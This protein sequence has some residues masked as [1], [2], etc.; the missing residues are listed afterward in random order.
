MRGK[1]VLEKLLPAWR[2]VVPR[3]NVSDGEFT[4]FIN[5]NR[6]RIEA[7]LEQ[8]YRR[9][10]W[11]RSLPLAKRAFARKLAE[12]LREPKPDLAV[13]L[14]LAVQI[15]TPTALEFW[16][17]HEGLS[18]D[19]RAGRLASLIK[20]LE[21]G[22]TIPEGA[23]AE[24]AQVVDLTAARDARTKRKR[25]EANL[26]AMTL[27]MALS[28]NKQEADDTERQ[29]L[30]GYSGWGGLD[31]DRYAPSFPDGWVKETQGLIHE[32]Y[33]PTA[34][35]DAIAEAVCPLLD[36]VAT[37]RNQINALEPSAGIGR[38]ID[39]FDRARC[40]KEPELHWSAVEL[41]S[42]SARLLRLIRPDVDLEEGN[43]E[44]WIAKYGAE[45]QGEFQLVVANPPYGQRGTSRADDPDPSYSKESAAAWYFLRRGL[46]ILAPQ[47]IGVFL[48][49]AG[50]LTGTSPAKKE[51]RRKVL[52]RHHLSWAVRLPGSIFPGVRQDHAVDVLVFRARGGEL[53]DVD[54][55]DAFIYEGNYFDDF[56]DHD[57][58]ERTTFQGLPPLDERTACEACV[59][60]TFGWD[61]PTAPRRTPI[62]ADDPALVKNLSDAVRQA[63]QVGR[64]VR[65]YRAAVAA[66]DRVAHDLRPE[67]LADLE[68]LAKDDAT[69]KTIR[70]LAE[71]SG[72]TNAEV[73]SAAISA[74]GRPDLPE[75]GPEAARY[76]GEPDNIVA[77]AWTLY[78]DRRR[79]TVPELLEFHQS[80]GGSMERDDAL[81]ALFDGDWCLDGPTLTHVVPLADYVTG[82]V[83]GRKIELELAELSAAAS[84]RPQLAKQREKLERALAPALFSEI[85]GVS[86]RQGWVPLRLVAEWAGE[87]LAMHRPPPLERRGGLVHLRGHSYSRLDQ[88][89]VSE[90]LVRLF[91]Y[92]NHD[93]GYFTPSYDPPSTDATLPPG[94]TAMT[95]PLWEPGPLDDRVPRKELRRRW[96]LFYEKD[97]YGWLRK[98]PERT[99]AV[100]EAYNRAFRSYIHREYPTDPLPIARWGDEIT[101]APHQNAGAR[102]VLAQRGGLLAFD[103]GVGKTFTALAVIARARQ[104]GWA[105]RPIVVVPKTL[106]WK[107]HRD[108][109]RCLPDFRVVVIGSELY[110]SARGA[111]VKAAKADLKA[112]RIT[113]EEYEVRITRSR[114]ESGIARAAKWGQ[115]Q[116]GLFDVAIVSYDVFA[117]NRILPES[118]ERY[119][120]SQSAM[121]RSAEITL[122]QASGKDS[123]QLTQRQKAV[124]EHGVRGWLQDQLSSSLSPD[125]GVVWEELGVDLLVV[126][127]A[128][129]FKN[130]HMAEPREG[131]SPRYMGGAGRSGSKRAF[132]FD[133]RAALV[134]ESTGG[135]GVVLLSATPAK[136]SPLEFYNMIQYIDGG[137]WSSLGID[138]PEQFIDRYCKIN[139]APVVSAA[140]KVEMKAAVTGFTNLDELRS[141]VF[142]YG[143]FRKAKDVGIKLPKPRVHRCQ[144]D[145]DDVQREKYQEFVARIQA[146]LTDKK[147]SASILGDLARLGLIALHGRLDE[148]YSWRTAFGGEEKRK[149]GPTAIGTWSNLGYEVVENAGDGDEVVMRRMLPNVQPHSPKFRAVAQRVVA[150]PTCGHIIFCEP[151]AAHAWIREVLVEYGIPK[152]RIAVI[153][154]EVTEANDRTKIARAFNGEEMDPKYD[155]V[156]ANSVAN[157]GI[158]LQ[159]RTCAIHHVDIPWTPADLEQRNGRGYR[160][161]NSNSTIA[162]YYYLA[163][164]SMDLFRFDLINGKAGW[165]DDL[166][167]GNPETSNPAAHDELSPQD[168]LVALSSNPEETRELIEKIRARDA[169]ARTARLRESANR[170]LVALSAARRTLAGL[171]DADPQ[172]AELRRTIDESAAKLQSIDPSVWPYA[173]LLDAAQEHEI[174]LS[175]P[176]GI[177]LFAGQRL[178]RLTEAGALGDGLSAFVEIG[179]PLR[180]TS[181]E[182]V[183]AAVRLAGTAR[184]ERRW[185]GTLEAELDE[186]SFVTPSQW[187]GEDLP[188]MVE[189]AHSIVSSETLMS[190]LQVTFRG[191][192]EAFRVALWP[193]IGA[194]MVEAGAKERIP[195]PAVVDGALALVE[196][197]PPEGSEVLPWTPE[198][199][200][201]AVELGRPKAL[202]WRDLNRASRLWWG[203]SFPRGEVDA[204]TVRAQGDDPQSA[205]IR[206][207]LAEA[208]DPFLTAHALADALQLTGQPLP[209][210]LKE[211]L[212]N[213]SP[214]PEERQRDTTTS[215]AAQPHSQTAARFFKALGALEEEDRKRIQR[216]AASPEGYARLLT[217][218]ESLAEFRNPADIVENFPSELREFVENYIT[219][220]RKGHGADEPWALEDFLTQL[221]AQMTDTDYLHAAAE[222]GRGGQGLHVEGM[223]IR[224]DEET[225]YYVMRD[226]SGSASRR[227]IRLLDDFDPYSEALR[228]E[229]IEHAGNEGRPLAT[230]D[231][232]YRDEPG[233]EDDE[234]RD[235]WAIYQ[236][237][238]ETLRA[239]PAALDQA[240]ELLVVARELIESPRCQGNAKT[241]ALRAL[242]AASGHYFDAARRLREGAHGAV[243]ANLRRVSRFLALQSQRIA[244]S[245]S[246][247]QTSLGLGGTLD[248]SNVSDAALAEA[249]AHFDA[250]DEDNYDEDEE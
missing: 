86:P 18:D 185:F 62:A 46:D 27:A 106:L 216:D 243:Y 239:A 171:D 198:G 121:M 153:N 73:L 59:I 119:A 34:V 179:H 141:I 14:P 169:S 193:V 125:P 57:L 108:F 241:D 128:A 25:S 132:N 203:R 99:A 124:K 103:V 231:Y 180:D 247:G 165:L 238:A 61:R 82:D 8:W 102:R 191:A 232:L 33:T 54:D 235:T 12:Q 109:Q 55:S 221:D 126:D 245:C 15:E 71:T 39:A 233:L 222:V 197:P 42:S 16:Q 218:L 194:A 175:S 172:A 83:G 167:A 174:F 101:L 178:R 166:V 91:G 5:T 244:E 158:D 129:S 87:M 248:M 21:R 10:Q 63:L 173:Q 127:E 157:E 214:A 68:S 160:Q 36:S 19:E 80:I 228:F 122:R 81:A 148:G 92:L 78:R 110:K 130:L 41:S 229:N 45:L 93:P 123:K 249:D 134:R 69:L 96:I 138:D 30:R 112:G 213:P 190:L 37:P 186:R 64:R 77:Q 72:S 76:I 164:G 199:F 210:V 149:V 195:L 181:A 154:A 79:L 211:A 250:D 49:P 212:A 202:L 184:W 3:E 38:F 223:A 187:P 242:K 182:P 89:G 114:T 22:G 90:T 40:G 163:K 159:V 4:R 225:G 43:F 53:A 52:R 47:G 145:L 152:E 66:G 113:T 188:A 168:I 44:S 6:E 215:G 70:K 105:R 111:R 200:G 116:A 133:V 31:L 224:G 20:I 115:F 205:M 60:N 147:K 135:A 230:G 17:D 217:A 196:G 137:A 94:S 204:D 139:A 136:N 236:E 74:T 161:G 13:L 65:Q 209:D 32:Y 144:V 100:T 26:A 98:N 95:T 97:F 183:D 177:P 234:I 131:G 219:R 146:A 23:E 35:A 156:I 56:P 2:A 220:E 162:I 207:Q 208:A 7:L 143:E 85:Q 9:R 28:E 227:Y 176:T 192:S 170:R 48:V 206:K 51:L 29:V 11:R 226:D 88:T 50:F 151:T 24:P 189:D 84:L 246:L 120:G 118:L 107:W 237:L 150:Q 67:L 140:F 1:Q 58:S 155:V 240:R 142:R 75:P 201:R 104:E 117:R